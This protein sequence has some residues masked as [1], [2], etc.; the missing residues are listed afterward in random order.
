MN[1]KT[2]EH[3]GWTLR[4]RQPTS[5]GPHAAAF[6]LH[7]WMGTE[8][9]M[10][11]F[12]GK[13]PENVL[14]IAPR[15]PF[16]A[17][18]GYTWVR[19]RTDGFSDLSMFQ[20]AVERLQTLPASLSSLFHADLSAVHLMGFSQ[21]AAACYA[22]AATQPDQVKSLAGLAG[23][24]PE[25]IETLTDQKPLKGIP[26]FMGHGIQDDI[27][28]IEVMRRGAAVIA[29]AGANLDTCED[30]VGHKLSARCMR[31]LGSFYEDVFNS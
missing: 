16:K 24:V 2:L 15:A 1:T 6:L 29:R 3:A 19:S 13:I 31:A 22:W 27:V 5:P 10:W 18:E 23:F 28:P 26:V 25:G 21:G 4:V 7:G 9:V 30:D 11:V 8:D 14:I 12:A 20:E 17:P